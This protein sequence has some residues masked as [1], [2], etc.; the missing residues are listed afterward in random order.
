MKSKKP[1]IMTPFDDLITPP[2]LYAMKLLLP[3]LPPGLQHVLAV[4]IK[5]TELSRTIADFRGFSGFSPEDLLTELKS[6]M[7]REELDQL[8]QMES[9][10]NIMEMMRQTDAADMM[11]EFMKG[12]FPDERMDRPPH[13][14]G[15]GSGESCADP[16]GCRED[17]G[18]IREKPGAGHD[19]ADHRSR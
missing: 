15:Y 16:A 6:C 12:V 17:E 13:D 5:V 9:V 19:V 4:Y 8:E 18:Q 7:S 11:Q 2:G 10:M 3:C 14:E 1:R